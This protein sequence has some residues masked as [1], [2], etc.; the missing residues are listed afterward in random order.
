MNEIGPFIEVLKRHD[1]ELRGLA[2]RLLRERTA[3]DDVMQE[4]YLKAYRGLADFRG[5]SQAKT[6]LYR[7]VYN[8]CLDRLRS[9]G[10][11]REVLLDGGEDPLRVGG[12]AVTA[13]I[14]AT[15]ADPADMV[16]DRCD[17]AAALATLA[18]DQR[19]AVLLVDAMGFSYDEAAEVVGVRP[20]TIGSRL[21]HARAVLRT[22]LVEWRDHERS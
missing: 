9:D 10:R 19:A 3:M 1:R 7:I 17:L 15:A 20:G 18:P 21:N 13:G 14:A 5:E 12:T 2:Y 22:T 6:W 8:A 11:R 4:A 16:A